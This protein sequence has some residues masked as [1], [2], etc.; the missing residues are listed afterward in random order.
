MSGVKK[1]LSGFQNRKRKIEECK[2]F[3]E[4]K[5]F[6]NIEKYIA[7]KKTESLSDTQASGKTAEIND[8]D[9]HAV[10]SPISSEKEKESQIL[11][12]IHPKLLKKYQWIYQI[13]VVGLIV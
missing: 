7:T 6:M 3:E 2:K 4:S 10:N 11:L 1:K 8:S 5:K 12:M 9:C 13:A